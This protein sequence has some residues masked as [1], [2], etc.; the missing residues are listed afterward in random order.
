[1]VALIFLSFAAALYA[2]GAVYYKWFKSDE[3]NQENI[4]F[5]NNELIKA[6]KL[7]DDLK[8]ELYKHKPLQDPKTGKYIKKK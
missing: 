3:K 6:H 5:L 7:I 8:A 4:Y 2:I 1:M